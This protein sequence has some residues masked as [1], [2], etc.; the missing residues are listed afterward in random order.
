MADTSGQAEI[1][2]INIDKLA[3]GFADEE[4]VF[5]KFVTVTP[6]SARLCRW[7]QKTAGVLDSTDTTGITASQIAGVP[8]LALPPVAEQS[9]T[10]RESYVK[11]YMVESP[12]ISMEDIKDC[13][14][15]VLG[16]NVRDLTRGVANQEDH[17]IYALLS[18]SLLLSSSSMGSWGSGNPI[19]DLLS[20]AAAIRQQ[21]YD[22]S[23]LAVL[24]HPTDYKNLLYW[25]ISVKGSSI[26][27][28]ASQ[29]VESGV[30]MNIVGQKLVV[31]NN[32]TQGIPVQIVPNRV[33]TWKTFTPIT[34]V[35]K[36]EPGIGTKIRVY[37]EGVCTLTDP[38][39][40]Y[41]IKGA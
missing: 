37:E 13:D 41:V 40:G 10:R 33:A 3:K 34:A 28:F 35:T 27:S 22:I 17:A 8:E 32:A 9:W 4:F 21:S 18:S 24:V 11:K 20:G 15:D 26:P 6:T 16:G 29:K 1:R 7:Y 2:G 25:L 38:N 31:S 36:E 30:L 19:G 23:D 14:P 39:A 12:W 5:K